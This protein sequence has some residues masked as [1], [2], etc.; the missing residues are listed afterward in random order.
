M[1]NNYVSIEQTKARY[2][3][4]EVNQ[5]EALANHLLMLANAET[6][7]QVDGIYQ[8]ACKTFKDNSGKRI[9]QYI[10]NRTDKE[11]AMPEYKTFIEAMNKS[12]AMCKE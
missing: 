11:K 7:R 1:N 6:V 3:P 2:F 10:K 4:E 5:N 8:S 12:L 9:R